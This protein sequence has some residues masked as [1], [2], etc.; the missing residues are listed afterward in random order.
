MIR[1]L[2]VDDHPLMREILSDILNSDVEISV[3]GT[4]CNG[5]A[6]LTF[7]DKRDVDVITMDARMPLMDGVETTREIMRTK[8]R[9]VVMV[10]GSWRPEDAATADRALAAGAVACL[11]KDMGDGY[12][13]YM[14]CALL[15]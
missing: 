3:V 12:P 14:G 10:Y 1:V 4:A 5:Q 11:E 13:V 7:L 2:I 15:T 9:P 8:P 6:A